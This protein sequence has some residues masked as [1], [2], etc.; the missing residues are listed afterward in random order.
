MDKKVKKIKKKST[1]I[2][3]LTL[4][5]IAKTSKIALDLKKYQQWLKSKENGYNSYFLEAKLRYKKIKAVRPS[6]C[7]LL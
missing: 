6:V 7:S 2:K 5:R 1:N 3:G 4:I